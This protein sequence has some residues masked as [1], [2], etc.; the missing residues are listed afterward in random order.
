MSIHHLLLSFFVKKLAIEY[1]LCLFLCSFP[2][3][4][5]FTSSSIIAAMFSQL[6]LGVL[7]TAF[8]FLCIGFTTC[9]SAM[10]FAAVQVVSLEKLS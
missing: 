7:L 1:E 10:F 6:A 8:F 3:M 2:V 9:P 4:S 5:G